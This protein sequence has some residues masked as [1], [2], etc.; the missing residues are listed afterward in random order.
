M[1]FANERNHFV[2]GC[3]FCHKNIMRGPVLAILLSLLFFPTLLKAW[4]EPV[5][6][7][8]ELRAIGKLLPSNENSMKMFKN[9]PLLLSNN[10]PFDSNS[11]IAVHFSIHL[12]NLVE[13]NEHF[14]RL[15]I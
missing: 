14:K 2:P 11:S 7:D 15:A 6:D 13:T 4:N 12:I 3:L 10:L 9:C 8:E 5:A 1:T